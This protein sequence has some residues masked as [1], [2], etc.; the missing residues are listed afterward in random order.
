MS[1]PTAAPVAVS[2]DD[3]ED[4]DGLFEE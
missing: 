4:S 3:E 2:A 1:N